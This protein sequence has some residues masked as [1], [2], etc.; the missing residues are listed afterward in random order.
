MSVTDRKKKVV[1]VLAGHDPSGAAGIQADIE[2]ITAN[3]ARCISV[4]TTLTSQ[5]TA[6]YLHS[7]PQSVDAFRDQCECLLDDIAID[8]CKIGLI[9]NLE[10]AEYIAGLLDK[11]GPLPVVL[12]PVLSAGSG[13]AL[14]DEELCQFVG[15]QLIKRSTVC[16]PNTAEAWRLCELEDTGAAGS[17]LLNAGCPNVLI[18]GADDN[19]VR[20]T[21]SLFRPGKQQEKFSWERLPGK[22]HGSGCTLSAAVA[23]NLARGVDVYKAIETAQDYTWQALKHGLKYG[24]SQHHPD[25]FWNI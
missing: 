23:A 8:A 24:S 17:W 16:T 1:L 21:N 22:F 10:L 25:R 12:D 15:Q 18:T 19:T 6:E 7:Y 3:G 4:I 13:T 5:N 14:A 9:S 20:V 11:L 2:S